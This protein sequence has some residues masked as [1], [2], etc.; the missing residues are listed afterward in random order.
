[1]ELEKIGA[2]EE[3]EEKEE[4]KEKEIFFPLLP[5]LQH[6]NSQNPSIMTKLNKHSYPTSLFYLDKIYMKLIFE[7]FAAQI[8]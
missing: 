7:K 1:M 5:H 3:E 8:T 6:K 2:R 4:K